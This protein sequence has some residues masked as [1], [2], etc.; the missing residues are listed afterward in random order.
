MAVL[1]MVLEAAEAA[2]QPVAA[3]LVAVKILTLEV[4]Y[5]YSA[6]E[7]AEAA[8]AVPEIIHLMDEVVLVLVAAAVLL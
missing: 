5:S 1:V 7:A 8:V 2:V 4:I 3:V 6:A